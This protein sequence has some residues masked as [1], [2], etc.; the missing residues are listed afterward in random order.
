MKKL[1]ALI[2][3]ASLIAA[4]AT[5]L[6]IKDNLFEQANAS[7]V[8][9]VD[10]G[11][12]VY[13]PHQ[14]ESLG[15]AYTPIDKF[16][17]NVYSIAYRGGKDTGAL[18]LFPNKEIY[19]EVDFNVVA[20]D[21][22]LVDT[23]YAYIRVYTDETHFETIDK[24]LASAH[25]VSY[26]IYSDAAQN[27]SIFLNRRT[28]PT[29]GIYQIVFCE[30]FVFPYASEDHSVKYVLKETMTFKNNYYFAFGDNSLDSQDSRYWGFIPEDFIIGIV[31]GKRVRNNPNQ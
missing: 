20:N 6:I 8:E 21:S 31:G 13:N 23:S 19:R 17:P 3:L 16:Q 30:G 9:Y 11:P 26:N 5:S 4:S 24:Y 12:A 28:L 27:V 18:M 15:P 10:L 25:P 1:S 2:L 7:N 22:E 14:N 29:H